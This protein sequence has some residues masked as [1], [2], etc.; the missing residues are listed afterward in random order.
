MTLDKT[1]LVALRKEAAKE[2]ARHT[3]EFKKWDNH[4]DMFKMDAWGE[5]VS[6][7]DDLIKRTN[8]LPKTTP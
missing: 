5:C 7:L 8:D 3:R 4:E 1:T 2:K 6:W